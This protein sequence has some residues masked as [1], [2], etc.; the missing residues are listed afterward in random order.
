VHKNECAWSE[1]KVADRVRV[2]FLELMG[3]GKAAG[4]DAVVDGGEV[5]WAFLKLA[6]VG[7]EEIFSRK[8]LGKVGYKESCH[9]KVEGEN[10][11]NPVHHVI[12]RKAGQLVSSGVVSPESERHECQPV[13]MIAFACLE[14][15]IV[16][17]TMLPLD[18][19]VGLQV[20]C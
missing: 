11:L 5:S 15:G 19:A 14:D 13:R 7:D 17:S 2:M 3:R 9:R 18:D 20:V 8:R 16:D 1:V 10:W 4:D 6:S 12:W